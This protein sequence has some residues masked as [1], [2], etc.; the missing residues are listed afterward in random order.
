MEYLA[1]CAETEPFKTSPKVSS[2]N[3]SS[4]KIAT[5]GDYPVVFP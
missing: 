2:S 3:I 4:G 1:T 5:P